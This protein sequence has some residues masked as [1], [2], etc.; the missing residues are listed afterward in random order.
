MINRRE[1][2]SSRRMIFW[3]LVVVVCAISFFPVVWVGLS[4]LKIPSQL[5]DSPV[6]Y[7][8]NPPTLQH[9]VD[10]FTLHPFGR[11]FLN[12]LWVAGWS[13][14]LTVTLAVLGAYPLTRLRF[15]G[16]NLVLVFI[17]ASGMLPVLARL[18][19]LFSTMRTLGLLNS[20]AGMVLV[21]SSLA[22]PLS[23]M[24]MIAFFG[25]VPRDLENAAII[26][27]CNRMGALWRIMVPL[28][29]PGM[30]TTALLSFIIAWNDF[31]I[32]LVL[33]S[34]PMMRTIPVGIALFPGEYQFPWGTISAAVIVAVI[35]IVVAIV[36]FQKRIV[37][38]LTSGAVKF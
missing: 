26:D 4:S 8:P 12:S 14:V 25:Q 1:R 5:Y 2:Q 10:V 9:Y 16:R 33:I 30:V 34:R 20:Y 17:L 36:F 24:T 23:T 35:P 32:A 3:G 22:L 37:A 29:A 15:R 18:I 13:T 11:F 38:G 31:I 28:A 6:R 27:G 19:P 21:Y 7:L